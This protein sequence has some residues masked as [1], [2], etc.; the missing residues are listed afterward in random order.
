MLRIPRVLSV[1]APGTA[2]HRGH[3]ANYREQPDGD[4][5][6]LHDQ[7]L[8]TASICQ[9]SAS[10]QRLT[11]AGRKRCSLKCHTLRANEFQGVDKAGAVFFHHGRSGAPVALT[12]LKGNPVRSAVPTAN[13]IWSCPR[14]CRRRVL[15]QVATGLCTTKPGKAEKD[16]DPRA[17]RT[18]WTK[19]SFRRA[20]RAHGAVFRSGDRGELSS[21]MGRPPCDVVFNVSSAV[22]PSRSWLA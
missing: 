7:P 17:R 6:E 15:L 10:R 22:R 8:G 12:G 3:L 21:G 14:N 5:N 13:Q 16:Q 9:T 18:A 2:E 19:S 4:Q 20:G 11:S 1:Y